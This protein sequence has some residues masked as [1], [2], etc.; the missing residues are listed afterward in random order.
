MSKTSSALG[1]RFR[2]F[3]GAW[4]P[5]TGA[6]LA[7]FSTASEARLL[8]FQAVF[9][10]FAALTV[11]WGLRT[12]WF[13]VIDQAVAA[14]PARP[15]EIRMR[16]L[17]WPD[18]NATLLAAAPHL[19]LVIDPAASGEVGQNGDVQ[20]EAQAHTLRFR[21][22]LGQYTI[23]YPAEWVMP[24]DRTGATAAWGA[25]RL[26]VLT[27]SGLATGA[28]VFLS[29]WL[30]AVLYTPL[31][32]LTAWAAGRTLTPGG[33]TKLARAALLGASLLMDFFL[34]LYAQYWISLPGLAAGFVVHLVAGWVW[35]GWG[36][37]S[38]PPKV[39]ST[40]APNPFDAAPSTS[41]STPVK[42]RNPFGS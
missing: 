3:V 30:L 26:P 15:A 31:V 17:R 25:W 19:A 18:T 22:V 7:A 13:P 11:V 36:T 14:L 20:I 5:F 39:H 1:G 23:L 24:L 37:F 6:G 28:V 4:Q 34:I 33:A 38:L 2:N 32:V 12:A 35:L 21:G 41:R 42:T 9:A 29:W 16:E 8:M 40:D 10:V 27:L